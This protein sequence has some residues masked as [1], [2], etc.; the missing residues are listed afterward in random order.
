MKVHLDCTVSGV[1][2]HKIT[3]WV[4]SGGFFRHK[5]TSFSVLLADAQL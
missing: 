2:K 1:A 3:M 5:S 4:M